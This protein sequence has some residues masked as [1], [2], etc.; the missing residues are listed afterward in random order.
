[1]SIASAEPQILLVDDQPLLR[2]SLLRH[3]HHVVP[4]ANV[5]LAHSGSDALL[6]CAQARVDLLIAELFL[7]DMHAFLLLQRLQTLGQ[8]PLIVLFACGATTDTQA[9][10]RRLQVRALLNKR[11]AGDRLE[12]ALHAVLAGDSI[13][14]A[15]QSHGRSCGYNSG[16]L[17]LTPRE[18]EVLLSLARGLSNKQIE[19]A[20]TI[21]SSTLKTHLRSLFDKFAV[22]NRTACLVSARHAGFL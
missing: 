7:T 16:S 6:H 15:F 20:L 5:A 12:Q 21:S 3:L 2:E 22:S 4:N 8:Q 10:A 17:D 13:Y 11:I 9:T 14:E 18:F 1:M 19:T